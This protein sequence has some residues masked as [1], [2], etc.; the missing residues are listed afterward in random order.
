MRQYP[1][2]LEGRHRD[3]RSQIVFEKLN[4]PLKKPVDLGGR[5][6]AIVQAEGFGMLSSWGTY[7]F[8]AIAPVTVRVPF[9]QPHQ[10]FLGLALFPPGAIFS[11]DKE[12]GRMH[13]A[14]PLPVRRAV[15]QLDG[16]SLIVILQH[17]GSVLKLKDRRKLDAM[18]FELNRDAHLL[19]G[20]AASDIA[21]PAANT[22]SWPGTADMP[23]CRLCGLRQPSTPYPSGGVSLG[24][25][26]VIL[27]LY[28]FI[29][30]SPAGDAPS[31]P[32]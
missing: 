10:L 30:S 2:S 28:W 1:L 24:Q 12:V 29:Y 13:Y 4:V 23:D 3:W 15:L 19:A 11:D 7:P 9:R 14:E 25:H 32:A 27:A 8:L 20:I 17:R 6:H 16:G 21:A 26:R 18:A 22:P 5:P 31:G